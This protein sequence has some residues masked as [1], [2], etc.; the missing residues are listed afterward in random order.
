MFQYEADL[1]MA[2][3]SFLTSSLHVELALKACGGK[4]RLHRIHS[5]FSNDLEI[6]SKSGKNG[7]GLRITGLKIRSFNP[8]V[9][10]EVKNYFGRHF[11][12]YI[13]HINSDQEPASGIKTLEDCC[14]RV[15]HQ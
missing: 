1:D 11:Q 15:S 14:N 8:P 7:T 2:I 9:K 5:K 13:L 12:K 6:K 3:G 4:R 10:T